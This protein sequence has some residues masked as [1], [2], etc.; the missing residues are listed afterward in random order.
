MNFVMMPTATDRTQAWTAIRQM[1]DHV[2]GE[3]DSVH[4]AL[5]Y[6]IHFDFLHAVYYRIWMD[7]SVSVN[8][9]VHTIINGELRFNNI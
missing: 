4:T 9:S 8:F 2:M 7:E 3:D 5:A 6:L 1:V